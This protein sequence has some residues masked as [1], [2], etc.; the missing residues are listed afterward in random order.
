LILTLKSSAEVETVCRELV[1]QGNVLHQTPQKNWD[2]FTLLK[3]L[4]GVPKD[5]QILDLGSGAGFTLKL[6]HQNGYLNLQG[7]DLTAPKKGLAN[8]LQKALQ[9]AAFQACYSITENDICDTGLPSA[10]F[11]F[12][13][14]ISVLEHGVDVDRY[15]SEVGRLLRPDGVMFATVDYWEDFE[16]NEH[17]PAAVCGLPWNIFNRRAL[18]AMISSAGLNGLQPLTTAEIPPCEE[19]PVHWAGRDYTFAGIALKKASGTL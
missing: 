4:E 6:M 13:T 3:L 2:H 12:I 16:P 5:A 11:D 15:L 7:V 18:E 10:S 17:E 8:R 19:K 14:C 9:P 1:E